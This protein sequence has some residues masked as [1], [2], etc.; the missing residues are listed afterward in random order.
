MKMKPRETESFERLQEY[1]TIYGETLDDLLEILEDTIMKCSYGIH[2]ENTVANKAMGQVVTM[3]NIVRD[4]IPQTL[5][6]D[7]E[8][9]YHFYNKLN[10]K[11][12]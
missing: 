2:S 9:V 10:A 3:F 7:I 12:K 1:G 8:T 6:G 5:F 11:E 4:Y